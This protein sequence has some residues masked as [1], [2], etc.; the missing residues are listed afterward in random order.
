[1]T[2]GF[3]AIFVCFQSFFFCCISKKVGLPKWLIGKEPTANTGATGDTGSISGSGGS[4][5][6]GNANPLQYS[7]QDKPRD[8]GARW[9][10]VHG[11]AKSQMRRSTPAF[12]CISKKITL[13][14]YI[15]KKAMAPHSSTL[16]WKIPWTEEPGGLQ[17]MGP[18][19]VGHD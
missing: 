3:E 11:I 6:E 7:C 5:G 12:I 9:A 16:A 8:R 1:M 14:I 13:R 4:P 17:S 19:R 18:L 2:L 10:T 15:T